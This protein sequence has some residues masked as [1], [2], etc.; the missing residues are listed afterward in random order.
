LTQLIPIRKLVLNLELIVLD[1]IS[2]DVLQVLLELIVGF[3]LEEVVQ[4]CVLFVIKDL[5]NELIVKVKTAHGLVHLLLSLVIDSLVQAIIDGVLALLL[6]GLL[7][8][9]L[10]SQSVFDLLDFI[11]FLVELGSLHLVKASFLYVNKA[12]VELFGL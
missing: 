8:V 11:F 4:D 9:H 7:L 5:F 2:L 10:F 6:K 3:L 12:E 1:F